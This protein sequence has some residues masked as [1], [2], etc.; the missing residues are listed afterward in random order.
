MRSIKPKGSAKNRKLSQ[1]MSC[2]LTPDIARLLQRVQHEKTDYAEEIAN[3]Y[4]KARRRLELAQF[5]SDAHD[6]ESEAGYDW[7]RTYAKWN[8]WEDPEEIARLEKEAREKKQT[9]EKSRAEQVMCTHDHSA[10]SIC[11]FVLIHRLTIL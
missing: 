2:G 10:V 11:K 9:Y 5:S 3:E 7:T 1:L 6:A 8:A 4:D